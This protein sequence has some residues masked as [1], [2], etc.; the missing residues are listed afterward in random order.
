MIG[1]WS[2]R[3]ALILKL[4]IFIEKLMPTSNIYL[5]VN[6]N[7]FMKKIRNNIWKEKNNTLTLIKTCCLPELRCV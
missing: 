2:S 4:K 6:S 1:N 5:K 3:T 7:A